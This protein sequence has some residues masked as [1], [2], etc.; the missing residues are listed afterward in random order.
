MNKRT[1]IVVLLLATLATLIAG[2]RQQPTAQEIVERVKAVEASTKDAHALLEI[3]IR[4][5][6][7]D[8]AMLVEVWESENRFRAEL[9]ESSSDEATAGSIIVNDGQQ[10]WI[11][12]PAQNTVLVGDAGADQPAGPLSS[13]RD[14]VQMVDE[15]IQWVLDRS[16]VKLVGEEEV[17]GAP[18]YKLSFAPREGQDL[19]FAAAS[20]G[21]LWVDQERWIVLQAQLEVEGVAESSMRVRSFELNPGIPDEVFTFDV[22]A[23][24]TLEKIE[25]R[26]PQHMTLDDARAMADSLLV[27]TFLPDGVTLVDVFRVEEAF[28]LHYDHSE[29]TFTVIQGPSQVGERPEGRTSEV[30]VRGVTGTLI[31]D[32]DQGNRFLTWTEG[33]LT[34]VI[35]GHVE[36]QDLLRVAESLR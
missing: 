36:E 2:C 31:A 20:E 6:S 11:Y 32:P 16:E 29:T 18:T 23:G 33:E 10:V 28:V 15:A 26:L 19:P 27:P 5:P 14:M 35:A 13:P 4:D 9:L 25:R 12:D 24:A 30:A 22:P 1:R 7:R 8:I 34:Y 17:A 3:E 21:T